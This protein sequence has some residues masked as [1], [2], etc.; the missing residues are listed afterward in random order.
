MVLRAKEEIVV[1]RLLKEMLGRLV[2]DKVA[3]LWK[4]RLER[5]VTRNTSDMTSIWMEQVMPTGQGVEL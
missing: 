1:R 4:R 2:L 5:H 3:G